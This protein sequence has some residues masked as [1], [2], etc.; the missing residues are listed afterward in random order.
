MLLY[1]LR[2]HIHLIPAHTLIHSHS[3]FTS[4]FSSF[5]GT[6][7]SVRYFPRTH[8]HTIF[9]LLAS[10][11][12]RK[13]EILYEAKGRILYSSVCMWAESSGQCLLLIDPRNTVGFVDAMGEG[14]RGGR[15]LVYGKQ[16]KGI[17]NGVASA[18][19]TTSSYT[20][21]AMQY[22]HK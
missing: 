8:T 20:R 1:P 19:S 18:G 17:R 13:A 4:I 7:C 14:G 22:H 10:N 5:A 2:S 3:L 9:F 15:E 6:I 16:E 12:L 11:S 21:K